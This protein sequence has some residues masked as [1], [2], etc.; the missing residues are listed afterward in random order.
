MMNI[1]VTFH[2][3]PSSSDFR[4]MPTSYTVFFKFRSFSDLASSTTSAVSVNATGCRQERARSTPC[5]TISSSTSRSSW[6]NFEKTT[7]NR[8]V[9]LKSLSPF[10]ISSLIAIFWCVILRRSLLQVGRIREN[11]AQQ[12]EWIQ[13]S[14]QTQASHLKNFR[15]IGSQHISTLKDQYCDQVR[16]FC[17][18]HFPADYTNYRWRT[19]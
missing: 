9:I 19:P 16:S 13:S 12:M 18:F 7:R 17:R 6:R 5:W 4:R 3:V 2:D 11:C 10:K 1:K 14:Y 15:D 8:L